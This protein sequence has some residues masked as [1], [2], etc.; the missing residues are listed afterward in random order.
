MDAE[1]SRLGACLCLT[2]T[3]GGCQQRQRR[4]AG[5]RLGRRLGPEQLG[6][7]GSRAPWHCRRHV[8]DARPPARLCAQVVVLNGAAHL[9]PRVLAQLGALRAQR[10]GLVVMTDSDVA[11]RQSRNKI[12]QALPGCLHAFVPAPVSTSAFDTT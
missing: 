2:G 1:V 11:G 3:W 9:T 8:N 10:G 7:L 12:E 5:V 6:K 4:G